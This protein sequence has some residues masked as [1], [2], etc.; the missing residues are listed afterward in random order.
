M[1]LR[2]GRP[3]NSEFFRFSVS[4]SCSGLFNG[5]AE[6]SVIGVRIMPQLR[7]SAPGSF[8]DLS[9]G[10]LNP[11]PKVAANL[12]SRAVPFGLIAGCMAL[13]TVFLA[14]GLVHGRQSS[15]STRPVTGMVVGVDGR[16]LEEVRVFYS[17]REGQS[18]WGK[19]VA[20]G[21]V[22]SSGR[23]QLSMPRS[24]EAG[25]RPNFGAL[26]AYRPGSLIGIV[27]ISE[28]TFPEGLP[29]RLVIGPAAICRFEVRDPDGR[30]VAGATITPRVLARHFAS[31]PD[32]LAELIAAE[33]RTDKQGRAVLKE[34]PPRRGEH[35]RRDRPGIGE[36]AIRLW[37]P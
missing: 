20:E 36:P 2:P 10:G 27:S 33:T 4:N 37:A 30:P 34:L 16:S 19:V 28:Q 22:D 29:A 23:F 1:R 17:E 13:F 31:V 14:A 24:K 5:Q 8:H 35:D 15:E 32:G 11:A 3:S 12:G 21:R 6:P 26:W 25:I 18:N 7:P 9:A